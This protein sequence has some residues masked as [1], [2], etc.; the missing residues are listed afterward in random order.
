MVIKQG[1]IYLVNFNPSKGTE[2]GKVRSALVVQT[3]LLNQL[4]HPSTLVMPLTTVLS[5]VQNVLRFRINKRDK[6][7]QNSDL[8]LEQIRAID[9]QRFCSDVLTELTQNEWRQVK[10]AALKLMF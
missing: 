3:D 8:M 9:N 7:E 1:A 5:S 10:A 6:L 4:E 2:A